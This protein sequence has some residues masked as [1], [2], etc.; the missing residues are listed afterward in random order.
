MFQL[1]CQYQTYIYKIHY[2]FVSLAQW[3][4][5]I[6]SV[7]VSLLSFHIC[8]LL[9][10]FFSRTYF[11]ANKRFFPFSCYYH[12]N[13]YYSICIFI[14][15][16]SMFVVQWLYLYT[17]MRKS[18]IFAS[19]FIKSNDSNQKIKWSRKRNWMMHIHSLFRLLFNLSNFS[20]SNGKYSV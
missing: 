3:C 14:K 20:Y 15:Y 9:F 7:L 10:V 8:L 19:A 17:S 5:H 6:K 18:K 1:F 4:L 13:C 12:Y 11:M 16:T 2:I